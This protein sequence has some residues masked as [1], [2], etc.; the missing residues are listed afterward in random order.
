[1]GYRIEQMSGEFRIPADKRADALKAVQAMNPTD[2]RF[3]WVDQD[4][5][6][7]AE[8]LV[9]A[10]WAWWWEAVQD[11]EGN[12]VDIAF[13]GEKAGDDEVL[14]AAIAPYV[15]VGS[16]IQMQGED[17]EIWRWVFTGAAFREDY[18]TIT[19]PT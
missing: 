11:P 2:A 1:M 7:Q 8:T 16:Y 17:A 3:S 19:W 15:D 5:V 18:P 14:F 9:D 4:E 6:V 10:L 13:V 12:I